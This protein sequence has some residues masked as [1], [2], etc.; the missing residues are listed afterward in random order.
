MRVFDQSFAMIT[1][2]T[3]G[4]K[5]NPGGSMKNVWIDSGVFV[6]LYL[7]ACLLA[8]FELFAPIVLSALVFG[9]I[10]WLYGKALGCP[11]GRWQAFPMAMAG[12]CL[13]A[14]DYVWYIDGLFMG[15]VSV[16]AMMMIYAVI[17]TGLFVFFWLIPYCHKQLGSLMGR[18][19]IRA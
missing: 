18:L 11:P 13:L 6:M 17:A 12:G 19:S 2:V 1:P 7:T 4:A 5:R 14:F 3:Q 9:L 15:L 16:F 8:Y 10:F